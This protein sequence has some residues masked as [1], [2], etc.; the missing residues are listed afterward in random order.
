LFI[1]FLLGIILHYIFC[2]D[3]TINKFIVSLIGR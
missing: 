3:T 2:V 1:L